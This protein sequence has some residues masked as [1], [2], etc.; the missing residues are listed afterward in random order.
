MTSILVADDHAI[1][2]K[3]LVQIIS[4]AMGLEVTGEASNGGEVIDMIRKGSYDVL[5]LD[6]NM[7]DQSGLDTLKQVK[8]EYPDLPVLILSVHGENQ[9][10]VRVLKAGA[11]GYLTK[12]SAPDQLVAAIRRV[13]EGKRYLSPAAAELLI[14]VLDG[15]ADQPVHA[16][17]SDREFQVMKMLAM[18]KSVMEIGDILSLSVKTISTYRSRVMEKMKMKSNAELARYALEN[19]LIV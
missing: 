16:M 2:R 7:P 8:S 18:G 14:E 3:G 12:E 10:A 5:V 17:L 11:S 4:S 15:D 6:L 19:D 13:A 9:Y 1:V